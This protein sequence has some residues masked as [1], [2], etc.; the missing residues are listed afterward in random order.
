MNGP[1]YNPPPS[2]LPGQASQYVEQVVAP[3]LK[4]LLFLLEERRVCD[5]EAIPPNFVFELRDGLGLSRCAILQRVPGES[6]S[7]PRFTFLAFA[8]KEAISCEKVLDISSRSECLSL[9]EKGHWLPINDELLDV[10][11]S[12]H[13]LDKFSPK[14]GDF[15]CVGFPLLKNHEL[16]GLL[17]F[18]LCQ[19]KFPGYLLDLG[20][21]V[22]RLLSLRLRSK[23]DNV[24]PDQTWDAG[25]SLSAASCENS[26]LP[27]VILDGASRL[28][29]N[30]N[31]A[32]SVIFQKEV[33]HADRQ[34][35]GRELK[36]LMPAAAHF[37]SSLEIALDRHKSFSCFSLSSDDLCAYGI[38][39]VLITRGQA[40]L[41]NL[42][43]IAGS[44]IE[45]GEENAPVQSPKN[46]PESDEE[47]G[48]RFACERWL[49]QTIGKL[50]ASLDRD[51][52]LQTLADNLGRAFKV[53]RCLIIRTDG[54]ANPMVTHEYVEPELSPLGL[55][56][57]GQF[58]LFT[59]KLFE[60]K[61]ASYADVREL[62]GR[63]SVRDIE[64]LEEN[65]VRGITGGPLFYQGTT[66]GVVILVNANKTRALTSEEVDLLDAV[67]VQASIAFAHSSAY[68]QLKDQLF[69]MSL[70]GNLAKQLTSALE[71]ASKNQGRGEDKPG[72]Q[73][74]ASES[75]GLSARELEVLRLI[76]SGLP[77]K[78]VGQRLF[79][80][81]S[82]VEL[83][84][85]RIRKKLGLKSRTALV[86]YA[87]D[88][89]L[90]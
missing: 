68:H 16:A 33:G 8:S 28:I 49:R 86:K 59:L 4:L 10:E 88:H 3:V 75:S 12:L 27:T 82:T 57:T 79:L 58:P 34:F 46:S 6:L 56:R 23:F 39:A 19:A 90:T 73:E 80:T 70:L 55:G 62:V 2:P 74:G 61:T 24:A 87:C 81:E 65:S 5:L 41:I 30:L 15:S 21:L 22:A 20:Q 60:K 7:G 9:L 52:L 53:T 14:D 63:L 67:L 44:L 50:H 83:H 25:D 76:A 40:G 54:F 51:Y 38:S 47:M 31:R 43:F 13:D 35:I 64:T 37:L 69:H 17:I 48:R 72:P 18:D 26:L 36:T 1:E 32:A 66:F 77:N 45:A 78:E 29:L 85:S 71:V 84:A 11:A 89:G 42:Q